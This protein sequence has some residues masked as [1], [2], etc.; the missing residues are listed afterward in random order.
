MTMFI[1]FFSAGV[2]GITLTCEPQPE[3]PLRA[4]ARNARAKTVALERARVCK[5]IPSD[6]G[7]Q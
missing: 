7:A 5:F 3:Q 6:G 2:S 4:N 1:S